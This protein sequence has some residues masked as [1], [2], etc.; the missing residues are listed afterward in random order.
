MDAA[1]TQ[2]PELLPLSAYRYSFPVSQCVDVIKLL[3]RLRHTDALSSKGRTVCGYLANSVPLI[4]Q[5]KLRAAV[6]IK[7]TWKEKRQMLHQLQGESRQIPL[8][9]DQSKGMVGNHRFTRNASKIPRVPK[10]AQIIV[11]AKESGA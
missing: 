6:A 1:L 3:K 9:A 7:L 4:R 8:T 5:L 2:H 10:A 11:K